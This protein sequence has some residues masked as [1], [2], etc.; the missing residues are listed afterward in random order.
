MTKASKTPL[1]SCAPN[2]LRDVGT[3]TAGDT[4]CARLIE[5]TPKTV[6][7]NVKVKSSVFSLVHNIDSIWDNLL[8]HRARKSYFKYW[9]EYSSELE[10]NELDLG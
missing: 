3:K 7:I 4:I 8:F 2:L 5:H 6:Q 9:T 10:K 1:D